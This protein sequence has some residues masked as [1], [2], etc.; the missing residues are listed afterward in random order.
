MNLQ[1][2]YSQKPSCIPTTPTKHRYQ[3]DDFAYLSPTKKFKCADSIPSLIGHDSELDEASSF[4]D[5]LD[6]SPLSASIDD[7][8]ICN[9]SYSNQYFLHPE[10][11]NSSVSENTIDHQIEGTEKLAREAIRSALKTNKILTTNYCINLILGWGGNGV[12]IGGKSKLNNSNIAIKLIY[13]RDEKLNSSLPTLPNNLPSEIQILSTLNRKL[14]KEKINDSSI[15]KFI[16]WFEDDKNY[17]LVTSR[18]ESNWNETNFFGDKIFEKEETLRT[19]NY[20]GETLTLAIRSG[21]SDLFSYIDS[22]TI[23][24]I[25]LQKVIFKQIAQGLAILHQNDITHGDIK[26]ENI[27]LNEMF[28]PKII[29]FGHAKKRNYCKKKKTYLNK[30]S[31]YGTRDMTA[32]EILINL[33]NKYNSDIPLR[34]FS[35]FENDIWA[36]GL[37]LYAMCFGTLSSVD[38]K[39][40]IRDCQEEN[41]FGDYYPGKFFKIRDRNLTNLLKGM[42]TIDPKKRFNIFQ[43]LDHP[44]LR[45]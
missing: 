21:G 42:L 14:N 23:V 7:H 1:S 27:L 40:F 34:K 28:Q 26:E 13:K 41:F 19:K 37:L 30:I 35:G 3:L 38:H 12:V 20:F 45:D 4:S 5:L 10:H 15:I 2:S 8:S 32:P 24:P 29:D 33:N 43:V 36:L 22:N 16:D 39:R 17:Y 11:L 44:Y 6:S 25:N 9:S 31:F 18:I